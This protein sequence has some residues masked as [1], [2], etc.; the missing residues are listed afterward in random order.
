MA[1]ALQDCDQTLKLRDSQNDFNRAM[2][3]KL[4]AEEQLG[5][6]AEQRTE[7]QGAELEGARDE[8]KSVQAE[9]AELREASSKY[10]EDALVEI[11]KLQARAEDTKKM[12]AGVPEE[13]VAAK[14]AALA[15]YQ[16]S[17]EFQQVQ[18]KSLDDGIRAFIYNVWR[19]HPEWDLSFLGEVATEMVTEFNAPPKTPLAEPSMEFVP[20]AG[21][22][23]GVADS[24]LK[25]SMRTLLRSQPTVMRK[26]MRTMR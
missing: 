16:F 10:W 24:L 17:T 9:L 19:E 1:W 21:Q 13:V 15:E 20:P 12:L 26:L 7:T 14:T 5:K 6:D 8:L 23:P 11:S 18:G 25:L 3:E 2:K 4:R 22:S